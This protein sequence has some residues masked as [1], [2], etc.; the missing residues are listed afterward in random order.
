[1][2]FR[3]LGPLEVTG[4][5]GSDVKIG[6]PK[7][8]LLL[9]ILLA[10]AN[11]LVS[12]ESL[13]DGLWGPRPPESALSNLRTY[14]WS[15]RRLL[16]PADPATAPIMTDPHGYTIVV[17][18]ERLD[19]LA[20]ER[21]IADSADV[22]CRGDSGAAASRLQEALSLWR[23]AVLENVPLTT[24]A[25]VSTAQRL[26]EQRLTAVEELFDARLALGRHTEVVGELQSWVVRRPLRERLWG[27]LMLAL[28]RD[29]RQADALAAYQRLRDHL[30]DEIGIEPSAPLRTLQSR[31][32]HSDPALTASFGVAIAEARL[33]A[34]IRPRQL[35]PDVATFVGRD[36]ELA[37]LGGVLAPGDVA[38]TAPAVVIHGPPGAG[39]SA[40]AVRAVNLWSAYLPDGHLYVNLRGATS[41]VE[42][43]ASGEA[44]G[45]F[46]RAL[47]VAAADVPS[48]VDEAAAVFRSLVAGRRMAILL[49]NAAAAAQVRPLLPGTAGTPVL[50]TSR[51]GL[52]TL[53]G[54]THLRLGPLDP[55]AARAMLAALIGDARAA[56]DPSATGRL[57]E[58]CDHLPLGLHVAAS[59]LKTR[60]NWPVRCLVDRLDDERHRLTEL[61]AGDLAVRSSLALSHTILQRSEDPGDRAA[62]RALRMIGLSPVT[63]M[64]A[65]VVA[66]LAGTSATE[67]ERM[68][69]RLL[70]A[71]LV[72]PSGADRYQMH[73]LVRLFTHELA[74]ETIP[75][76]EATVAVTRLLGH[77]LATTRSATHLAYPSRTH[78]PVPDVPAARRP[79]AGPDEAR[80]WLETERANILALIRQSWHGPDEHAR[81]GVGL[82][83][84][85]HWFLVMEGYP[86]DMIE[87]NERAVSLARRL[88]DRRSEAYANGIIGLA[89]SLAG[90]PDEAE[91]HLAAELPICRELGDRFGEQRALGNLGVAY[92]LQNRSDEAIACLERQR[93]VAGQI[94]AAVGEVFA[95]SA[96][97][98]AYHQLGRYDE[99][100]RFTEKALAWY[101]EANDDYNGSAT[102]Q[103]L[104]LIYIDLGRLKDAADVLTCSV[105][106]ARRIRY[107][108]GETTSLIALARTWR[109]LGATVTA[110]NCAKAAVAIADTLGVT[111]VRAKAAAEYAAATA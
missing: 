7:L 103:R 13:V 15:L 75:A 111:Y 105:E 40:L 33:D 93:A 20:F 67:A 38:G 42:P 107:R 35:P 71:H 23:G 63:D 28:Y 85:L 58:L 61:A 77:Y 17:P 65:D 39:K 88:G 19:M 30:I 48:D 47:G 108:R 94:G 66:S 86:H 81:L 34:A 87:L 45:R 50:V 101:D 44:L 83:L 4:A 18:P 106:R 73:D 27:Q 36:D 78:Y 59:R 32:L 51:A 56:A 11:T 8:R 12:V 79:F 74:A 95:L 49:D 97:G 89:L 6:R 84:A 69:E 16:A 55:D 91:T 110:V 80:R 14:V 99:A 5:D 82:T 26:E 1:M 24:D 31:I 109:L 21:L 2:Q 57:A 53:N 72:E 102:L 98:Q 37:A 29:G 96:L 25:L 54:A 64:D 22:R 100:I 68:I 10:R 41:G 104:G 92:L 90:R 62:A 43:L 3:L 52:T 9:A 46:L 70:D 60:P 76:R